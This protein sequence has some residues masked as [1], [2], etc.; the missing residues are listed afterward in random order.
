MLNDD[1]ALLRRLP[2][3]GDVSNAKLK[4]LAL[5]CRRNHYAAGDVLIRQGADAL[6]L[7]ILVSGEVKVTR[8]RAGDAL[9]LARLGPGA[10]IGEIGVVLDTPY[11]SSVIA[12]TDLVVLEIGKTDFLELVKELPQL[13]MGLIRELARRVLRTSDLYE[14]ALKGH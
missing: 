5:A 6:S 8:E 3:F 11:T 9:V 10:I 12:A 7:F 14:A 4:L 13:S 1:V 2:M